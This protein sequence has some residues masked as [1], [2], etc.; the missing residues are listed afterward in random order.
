[1]LLLPA[2]IAFFITRWSIRVFGN[3][4]NPVA[5][6]SI[7][8]ATPIFFTAILDFLAEIWEI[9]FS[10]TLDQESSILLPPSLA[11]VAAIL[12][13]ALPWMFV[14]KIIILKRLR[15]KNYFL[16][17]ERSRLKKN[18]LIFS[19]GILLLV[20]F[21]GI[22]MGSI[23][24]V[25]M[26]RG[27]LDVRDSDQAAA[28]LPLGLLSVIT[29]GIMIVMLWAVS[30]FFDYQNG[31][32]DWGKYLL[33][34]LV[35]FPILFW[36]GKRQNLLFFIIVFGLKYLTEWSENINFRRNHI[37]P[38]KIFF[39]LSV[40]LVGT[41][42]FIDAIRYQDTGQGA[43]NSLILLGYVTWPARNII[44]I[45]QN[46]GFSG[47]ED[48]FG[49][50]LFTLAELVPAR[51][52]GKDLVLAS[53]ELLFEPTSPSGF[54]AYWWLDGGFLFSLFGVFGFSCFSMYIYAK[55]L[56]NPSWDRIYLLTLWCCITSGIYTHFIALNYFWLPFA[57]F[58]IEG[59][60]VGKRRLR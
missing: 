52:G 50:G 56:R 36:N 28:G 51:L 45:Y 59:I 12:V 57:F 40:V 54:L 43:S 60:L 38:W 47:V 39:V 5:L 30:F 44:S 7:G 58:V 31:K 8:L 48:G 42:V 9:D 2:L 18:I 10:V 20:G 33:F 24:L 35:F 49:D 27:S 17:S 55:R 29:V 14:S 37:S 16:V 13:F 11:Y 15:R 1:M 22:S 26:L 21:A 23:P 3:I 32:H 46:L 25:E 34:V 53:G 6:F 19:S 4:V 41:F